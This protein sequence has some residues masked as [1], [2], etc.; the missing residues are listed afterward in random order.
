VPQG[1]AVVFDFCLES[2]VVADTD[3]AHLLF[4]QAWHP[5]VAAV[6]RTTFIREKAVAS[7]NLDEPTVK[8]VTKLVN[9]GAK[10]TWEKT[11]KQWREGSSL[12]SE[13]EESLT[14]QDQKQREEKK[15]QEEKEKKE[16]EDADRD[17]QAAKEELERKRKEKEQAE[18]AKKEE[19]RKKV[20]EARKKE[21]EREPWRLDYR[22]MDA[23]Q[24]LTELQEARRDANLK[25]E[26]DESTRLTKE[27]SK[28]ERKLDSVT[29]KA[30]K[31]YK[32][33]WSCQGEKGERISQGCSW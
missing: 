14:N 24:K 23:R 13:L 30:Q 1:K 21:L 19:K 9:D 27:V 28:A 31:Y 18:A 10:K 11:V 8:A 25:M 16:A 6:E 12:I 22:V 33:T 4:L 15:A 32:K 26:F 3:N 5:E 7:W 17:L 2:N 20:E 29:E